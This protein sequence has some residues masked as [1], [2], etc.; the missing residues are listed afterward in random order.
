[1]GVRA[2]PLEEGSMALGFREVEGM[3][4]GKFDSSWHLLYLLEDAH[5]GLW[6]E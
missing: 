6:N 5:A 2:Q 4:A 1:M 3:V